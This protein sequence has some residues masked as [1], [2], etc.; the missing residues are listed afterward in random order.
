MADNKKH[1]DNNENK[2]NKV[3]SFFSPSKNKKEKGLTKEQ[4][5][6]NGKYDFINFFSFL[7]FRFGDITKSN[8]L[9]ILLNFSLL[10]MLF[11]L[12]GYTN[13]TITTPS[14][15]MYQ[16]VFGMLQYDNSS[17]AI[18]TYAAVSGVTA[19][20]SVWTIWTQLLVYSGYSL[21]VT[22]GL[23]NIGMAY[24]TRGFVRRDHLFV[25]HDFWQSIKKNWVQGI[26]VGV[27][28]L[29]V[30]YLLYNALMFYGANRVDY[31]MQLFFYLTIAFAAIYLIMRMY[32]YFMIITFDLKLTKLIKNAMIFS[33]LGI[34]RNICAVLG[35]ALTLFLNIY[36]YIFLP[37]VGILIPF[38]F[39]AGFIY[40]ITAY[41][42]FPV[43]DK[44]M[45][46]PY[47]KSETGE[48]GGK[49][50]FTDRG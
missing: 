46:K 2:E 28:D 31:M 27:L 24:L 5:R 20:I 43:I 19:D 22:F 23:S 21:F 50:I 16:Q 29:G 41:C 26:I 11:A 3:F 30:C 32:F 36:I 12:T 13:K 45:I 4:A 44:Y 35:I 8:L 18:L 6:F 1:N 48:S 40:F 14:T 34:K 25:W 49:P 37:S 47:Y 7:K 33:L 17:A 15:P 39:T 10:L 9:F 38:V 42:V